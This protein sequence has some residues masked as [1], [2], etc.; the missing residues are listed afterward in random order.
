MAVARTTFGETEF[1]TV[2]RGTRQRC[3]LS[4]ILFN[5]YDEAMMREAFENVGSELW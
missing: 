1:I 3:V 4:L 5:I 2:G